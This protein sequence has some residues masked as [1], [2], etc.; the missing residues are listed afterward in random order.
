MNQDQEPPNMSGPIPQ[1]KAFEM[2]KNFEDAF[3][4][5]ILIGKTFKISYTLLQGLISQRKDLVLRFA[6][7][8][9]ELN[10]LF[11]DENTKTKLLI[12]PHVA[13]EVDS[14]VTDAMRNN[15]NDASKGLRPKFDN[16]ITRMFDDGTTHENTRQ[17]TIT[18]ENNFDAF[19]PQKYTGI[20]LQMAIDSNTTDRDRLH[21]LTFV[22]H[23]EPKAASPTKV[24][25]YDFMQL[26]PPGQCF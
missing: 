17:I 8:D 9:K 26:C 24:V 5:D 23:F 11:I 13:A 14:T 10:L 4:G 21:K 20:I 2:M 18:Y 7:V 16:Y 12:D 1:D 15:F 6:Q 19:D 3:G 25:Y 22:M